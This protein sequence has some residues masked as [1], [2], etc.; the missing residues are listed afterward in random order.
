MVT[1]WEVLLVV[2]C[3]AVLLFVGGAFVHRLL[4]SQGERL[5]GALEGLQAQE[6]DS[7]EDLPVDLMSRMAQ[8]ERRMEVLEQDALSYLR[9]GSQRYEQ[10]RRREA[11]LNDQEGDGE[12][13]ATDAEREQL[14][15][16]LAGGPV[17]DNGENASLSDI[18]ARM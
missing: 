16:S 10:S 9:K 11:R 1:F 18:R 14:E 8:M 2:G 15:L 3:L 5:T 17:P 6:A 12:G 13:L 4:K 7:G